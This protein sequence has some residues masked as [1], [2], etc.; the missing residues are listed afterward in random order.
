MH[1]YI[2]QE[3]LYLIILCLN[4]VLQFID[5]AFSFVQLIFLLAQQRIQF[6]LFSHVDIQHTLILADTV[7]HLGRI[8]QEVLTCADSWLPTS[9]ELFNNPCRLSL[10]AVAAI[11]ASMNFFLLHTK[12]T[13]G[14][15]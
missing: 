8:T 10:L 4:H 14:R 1:L 15:K 13:I 9:R 11:S 2:T 3:I 6:F 7:P 5:R 12:Y